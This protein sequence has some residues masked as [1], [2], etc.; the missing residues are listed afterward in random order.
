MGDILIG[1]SS[2]SERS[3]VHESGWYPHRSMKAAER[4]A[5]YA[6]RFPLVGIDATAR[7]PPTPELA[8]QWVDRT[9]PGFTI[10]IEGWTL[11]TGAATLPDSLWE[12]LRQEVRPEMRDRRRLYAGHL[13][14][15]GVREAWRRFRHAIEP[16]NESGRLGVVIM[17]YPRWLRPGDTGRAMMR[18]ARQRLHGLPVAVELR[19]P[20]WL[21]G[22]NC[23]PT[24]GFLEHHDLG[25]VCVD[26]LDHPPVLAATSDVAVVRFPGHG[27]EEVEWGGS[28]RYST[29]ELAG[30]V[31][32]LKDLAGGD[33][34]LHVLF[35]NTYKD[36]A[37]SNAAELAALLDRCTA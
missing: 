31:P 22:A 27:A 2:W 32:K 35:A 18:E 10:D 4:M 25:L 28:Y 1:A 16:L 13:T 24:L 14:R 20:A 11:F 7:F 15:A 12:D 21:E 30:W 9:P 8:R 23:E 19:D 33:G 29:P 36:F 34:C 5:Y 6:R 3:L 26:R 37:V 17:R